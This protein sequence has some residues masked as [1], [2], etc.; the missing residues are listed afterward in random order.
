MKLPLTVVDSAIVPQP[1]LA[2]RATCGMIGEEVAEEMDMDAMQMKPKASER[3]ME[4]P[5]RSGLHYFDSHSRSSGAKRFYIGYI[6]GSLPRRAV[7]PED[8]SDL[9]AQI[10]YLGSS[11]PMPGEPTYLRWLACSS[12]AQPSRKPT[13]DR[14]GDLH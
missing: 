9:R 6:R 12:I 14:D 2:S 4:Y 5:L 11:C 13:L 10:E 7:R 8:L 1:V 3:T